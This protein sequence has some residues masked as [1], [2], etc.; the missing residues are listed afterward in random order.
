MKTS[1]S[2]AALLAATGLALAP[3]LAS[4]SG[5]AYKD[6]VWSEA[7]ITEAD[8]TV[9]HA[10][11]LRPKG[12]TDANKTPVIL[13]IGP[14]FNHSGQTSA[15]GPVEGTSYDPV[16]PNAGPSERFQDFVEGAKL[17]T[18]DNKYTF[19]MVD[20]RGFGGST[21]CLDWGG[22]GEQADVVEAIKWAAKQPWSTGAVGTYGKSYDAM[23]GLMAAASRPA[24]LKAVVAQEPVYDNY[25]YLYGDGIRRENSLATPGLYDAI[26]ATPGPL[27][28]T[29]NP[30]YNVGAMQQDAQRPGC[31]GANYADQAGND[32]H[33]SPYWRVRNI[34]NNVKGSNVPVFITQGMTENNTAPDGTAE[35]LQNHTGPERG[36]LGPWN[37]VRGAELDGT[38]LAMGRKGWYDEVMRWYDKY[39]YGIEPTVQDPPFAI[40]SVTTGK[41]RPELQWPPADV[42]RLTTTDLASGTYT[43]NAQSTRTGSTGVWTVSTPLTSDVHLAGA[44]QVKV[45][46]SSPT[47]RSNLVVDLYDLDA[48]GKGPLVARQGS[49]IR[50][51]GTVT[52][53]L[54]SAD[55]RFAKGHR[56]G[57]RVTDNNS[58]WFLAAVPTMQ[59]VKVYGGEITLPLLTYARTQTIQGDSGTTRTAWTGQTA[60]APAAAIAAAKDFNVGGPMQP[61][62]ADMKAQLDSYN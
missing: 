48:T 46:V 12:L 25:R 21:G 8:G 55:W 14:Y 51:N 60:S 27:A 37:H 7:S 44:A 10:D 11:V 5:V 32:D 36:W 19:V 29:T 18:R 53:N 17:F 38:K 6:G 40:Q 39:L 9:L 50:S 52:L 42:Q 3:A 35:F 34:I 22:P 26:A 1:S 16:G 30:T 56:I 28:D 33:Y 45:D 61:E 2:I 49:L 23:T 24:E 15:A 31:F 41:W 59:D 47:P 4:A 13:S 57:V 54:M 20:L 58:D 62:P 43:D